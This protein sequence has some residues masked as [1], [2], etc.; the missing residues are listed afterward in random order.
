MCF[1]EIAQ[2]LR[3]VEPSMLPGDTKAFLIATQEFLVVFSNLPNRG[4]GVSLLG[5]RYLAAS[6]SDTIT[7]VFDESLARDIAGCI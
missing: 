5:N 2:L 3:L 6:G 1:Q 4:V 7:A